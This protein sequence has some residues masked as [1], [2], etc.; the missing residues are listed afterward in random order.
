[1]W[2]VV[3]VHPSTSLV[4]SNVSV[5]DSG[6]AYSCFDGVYSSQSTQ[7]EVFE[8][9]GRPF[10]V[11]LLAGYNCTIIAYGQTGSGKTYTVVGG[12]T[13]ET[14]GLIPRA[15]AAIFEEIAR[16]DPAEYDVSLTA[17]FVEIYQEK[18]RDLLLPNSSRILRLR[19]DKERNVRIEGASEITVSSVATG[20]AILSRGNGQR[21]TGST[22][23]N[24][25]SSRSHSVLILTLTK[26]HLT[27]GTKLRGKMSIVDLAG[28]EKVQKTAAAGVRMEEAK[29][30]NRSLSAL[31]NV[32]NALTDEKAKHIPYRDSKLTRLLQT[33]L[34]GNAKTHLLLTCSSSINHLE[35]TLST[36]RF[37]SR[38]KNIQNKPHVNNE[39][40]GAGVEYGE[41]LTSLQIKIENLHSYIRQL[42]MTPCKFCGSGFKI[43]TE[44]CEATIDVALDPV[45]PEEDTTTDI[46]DSIVDDVMRAE[47]QSLRKAL[48]KLMHDHETQEHAHNVA[49]SM[50]EVTEQQLDSRHRS[51]EQT[52]QQQELALQDASSMISRLEKKLE[53]LEETARVL[54][55]ELHRLRG[56]QHQQQA[57]ETAEAEIL[58]RQ[59]DTSTML[60]KQLEAKLM[61]SRQGQ[62]EMVDLRER[63]I[64]KEHELSSLRCEV[65]LLRSKKLPVTLPTAI[66]PG[67]SSP[68]RVS[69]TRPVTAVDVK[70]LASTSSASR[71][72]S[73]YCSIGM[74][75]IQNW[76]A[77]SVDEPARNQDEAPE[78]H[79][80]HVLSSSPTASKVF[81]GVKDEYLKR[82][83]VLPPADYVNRVCN[84]ASSAT[85]PF[86]SRLVGLLNS[87]EEET[88]AY[89]ELVV[90]TKERT[91][92]RSGGRP[93][94]PG[95]DTNLPSPKTP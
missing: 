61:A 57:G 7:E 10:V 26:K 56:Q 60:A 42:E 30:I 41:L 14:Q 76:W 95:L 89:R 84:S 6:T 34:G 80:E 24:A 19:E 77:G 67:L 81:S 65:E 73:K 15:M 9:V 22:L 31:G 21:S 18:L 25:D 50:M 82:G 78:R 51:Q 43:D 37:G 79:L 45:T 86:R 44:E 85:R 38:A 20:M 46:N 62:E 69:H 52:I 54:S 17:S 23:M 29:H 88:T 36:L 49:R 55:A 53:T 87:L 92:S 74:S 27:S 32:I 1:M 64:N 75:N 40:A 48:T 94:L 91:A 70:V 58:R 63:L 11:D 68:P 71:G 39:N 33:S 72:D 47:M 2:I 4:D 8:S 66:A 13:I 28:S 59:L 12:Q 83:H 90:E 3:V 16:I 93:R 5:G 35:E